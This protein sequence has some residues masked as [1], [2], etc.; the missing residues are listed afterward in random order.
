MTSGKRKILFVTTSLN[1][2]GAERQLLLLIERLGV[3]FDVELISLSSSGPL[4]QEYLKIIP[5]MQIC[6]FRQM[7][8]IKTFFQLF[9]SI[10]KTKPDLVITWLYKADILGG[11]ASKF[12]GS[13][14]VI[15]SARN[16]KVPDI[17]KTKIFILKF[18]SK[19]IP[20]K[21]VAN[22]LP[23]VQY[24]QSIGYPIK[25]YY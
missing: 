6:D 25:K 3:I 8:M 1:L 17:T 12:V 5:N 10:R 21:I 2:G 24:H 9:L 13:T 7:A 20:D 11:I 23:A 16:S 19:F 22:G 4:K 18:F 15:W 14:P